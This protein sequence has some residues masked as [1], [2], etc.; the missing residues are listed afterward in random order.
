MNR[1]ICLFH[2]DVCITD[3]CINIHSRMW[4]EAI[5][6]DNKYESKTL[7]YFNTMLTFE[8]CKFYIFDFKK[9]KRKMQLTNMQD[10]ALIQTNLK[11]TPMTV[12]SG[13]YS[14]VRYILLFEIIGS[15]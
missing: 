7:R 8:V 5:I 12:F 10:S 11:G 2:A 14:P 13:K 1:C 6:Y 9:L 3:T 4:K 15:L